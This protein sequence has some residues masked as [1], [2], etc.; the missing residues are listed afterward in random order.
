MSSGTCVD[1]NAE[2]ELTQSGACSTCGSNSVVKRNAIKELKEAIIAKTC[3][4]CGKLESEHCEF[5][6][7]DEI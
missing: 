4:H 6:G 2:V 5:E 3:I 7:V 1:C